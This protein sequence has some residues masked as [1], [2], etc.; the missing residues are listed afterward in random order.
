MG[1]GFILH[2]I[3]LKISGKLFRT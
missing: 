1:S 3:Y 2:E